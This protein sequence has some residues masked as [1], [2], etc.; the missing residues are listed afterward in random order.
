LRL[1]SLIVMVFSLIAS[2][3]R[4]LAFR[5]TAR[6]ANGTFDTYHSQDGKKQIRI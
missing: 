6:L 5:L 2:H 4:Q 3:K 1:R